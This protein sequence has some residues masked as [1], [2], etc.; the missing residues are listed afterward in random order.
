MVSSFYF[1]PDCVSL[2]GTKK[3]VILLFL[4]V[5]P[6]HSF[7]HFFHAFLAT[8]AFSAGLSWCWALTCQAVIHFTFLLLACHALSLL[9]HLTFDNIREL[10]CFG[11]VPHL[12]MFRIPSE[13]SSHPFMIPSL[14]EWFLKS[15]PKA[16]SCFGFCTPPGSVGVFPPSHHSEEPVAQGRRQKT[17]TCHV[18]TFMVQRGRNPNCEF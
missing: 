18:P 4:I 11:E 12:W 9:L 16:C 6:L 1:S 13:E 17:S 7:I 2:L 15:Q 3:L 8:L 5:N 10:R 14:P